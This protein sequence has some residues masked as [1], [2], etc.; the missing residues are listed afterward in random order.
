MLLC[1]SDVS[2]LRSY[3]KRE[4]IAVGR[5]A[6]RIHDLTERFGPIPEA[7]ATCISC[8]REAKYI[9]CCQEED[10]SERMK[11]GYAEQAA[12]ALSQYLRAEFQ[13]NFELPVC[14]THLND[15]Q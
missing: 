14:E 5:C 3:G 13:T 2:T 7:F 8:K 15:S 1:E 6:V 9:L 11:D 4:S 10:L 12:E